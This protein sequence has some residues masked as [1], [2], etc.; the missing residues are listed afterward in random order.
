MARHCK[1]VNKFFPKTGSELEWNAA[2]CRLEDYLRALHVFNKVHQ[3]QIILRLLQRAGEKHAQQPDLCPTVLA[4]AEIRAAMDR[5]FAE[6]LPPHER[7]SVVGFLA[8]LASAVPEKWPSAF[9][10]EEIPDDCR[11]ALHAN[12]VRA[13]PKLQVTSMVPQPFANPLLGGFDLPEPVEKLARYL[14]PLVMKGAVSAP[15]AAPPPEPPQ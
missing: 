3:T 8:L 6:F 2:Y 14:A 7:V 12:E 15:A 5:W 11:R 13:V 9:L 4:M 10:A 1:S